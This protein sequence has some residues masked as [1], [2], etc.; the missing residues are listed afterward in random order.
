M[1]L[2][3]K[4]SMSRS[5][6]VLETYW[7]NYQPKIEWYVYTFYVLTMRKKNDSARIECFFEI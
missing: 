3:S 7:N 4:R 6:S 5:G 1:P 2:L